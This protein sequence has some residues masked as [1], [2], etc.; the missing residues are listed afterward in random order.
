[1][2]Q[3]TLVYLLS[4]FTTSILPQLLSLGMSSLSLPNMYM[5]AHTFSEPFYSNLQTVCSFTL[6]NLGI[7]FLKQ[8][9]SL[10]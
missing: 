6:K 3:R 2:V 8:R 5:H 7:Q 4:K 10:T 9:H 1:M